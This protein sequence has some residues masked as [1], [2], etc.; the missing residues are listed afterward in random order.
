MVAGQGS[1]PFAVRLLN[2]TVNILAVCEIESMP[3]DC[4]WMAPVNIYSPTDYADKSTTTPPAPAGGLGWIGFCRG[5]GEGQGQVQ[6]LR[7]YQ[8]ITIDFPF[9]TDDED[10]DAEHVIGWDWDWDWDCLLMSYTSAST[11]WVS[12][13]VSKYLLSFVRNS[14]PPSHPP[15][16]IPAPF[17]CPS[18]HIHTQCG[19]T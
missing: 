8:K 7:C 16:S 18:S 2:G 4:T 15:L 19:A 17:N 3:W 1:I 12:E 9:S 11:F 6:Y 5:A 14:H 13:W 10:D